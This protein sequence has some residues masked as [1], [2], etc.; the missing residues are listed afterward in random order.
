MSRADYMRRYRKQVKADRA[1]SRKHYDPESE[2]S[3]LI[4]SIF[5]RLDGVELDDALAKVGHCQMYCGKDD[6]DGKW[7]AGPNYGPM[8]VRC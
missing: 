8:L 3:Q 5:T 4:E 2:R 7:I 6:P 1:K